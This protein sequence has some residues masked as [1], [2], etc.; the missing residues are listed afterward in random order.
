MSD[1]NFSLLAQEEALGLRSMYLE[2]GIA[3]SMET[4]LSDPVGEKVRFL[5]EAVR[6]GFF[7]VLLA[8]GLESPEKSQER[9]GLRVSRGGHNVKSE[10]IV[11]R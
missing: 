10:K 3:F 4:V 8:V 9:A 11:S 2:N 7:V 1:D 6:R 5:Q